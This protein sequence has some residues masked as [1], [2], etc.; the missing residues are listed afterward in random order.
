MGKNPS[1]SFKFAFLWSLI[2]FAF[3]TGALVKYLSAFLVFPCSAGYFLKSTLK[4]LILSSSP[5]KSASFPMFHAL[6]N[7]TT[8]QQGSQAKNFWSICDSSSSTSALSPEARIQLSKYPSNRSTSFYPLFWAIIR[9]CLN[10]VPRSSRSPASSSAPF[11]LPLRG[12]IREIFLKHKSAIT[13]L[14]QAL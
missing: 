14:L 5:Y 3:F 11:W 2:R 4:V 1:L 13:V 12:T 10:D 7:G 8:C 9:S 6:V